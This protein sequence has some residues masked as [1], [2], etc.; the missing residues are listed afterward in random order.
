MSLHDFDFV[1]DGW[2]RSP[3]LSQVLF[4]SHFMTVQKG[5]VDFIN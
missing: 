2:T 5:L 3:F 1:L 4:L